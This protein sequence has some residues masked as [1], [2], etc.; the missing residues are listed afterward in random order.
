MTRNQCHLMPEGPI[1]V[2]SVCCQHWL[3]PVPRCRHTIGLAH[4]IGHTHTHTHTPTLMHTHTHAHTH[5]HA[6]THTHTCTHTHT[7]TTTL[8]TGLRMEGWKCE[9]FWSGFVLSDREGYDRGR[10]HRY[11]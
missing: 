6:H 4:Y 9:V 1:R 7:H 3:P 2:Q 8:F 5:V 11:A 10:A